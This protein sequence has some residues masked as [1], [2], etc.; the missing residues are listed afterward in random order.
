[1]KVEKHT[2]PGRD[3]AADAAVLAAE[4][5]TRGFISLVYGGEAGKDAGSA[6]PKWDGRRGTRVCSRVFLQTI[7]N[8]EGY[9]KRAG[10]NVQTIEN[11]SSEAWRLVWKAEGERK[12]NEIAETGEFHKQL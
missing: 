11:M 2:A 8:K 1:M 4:N 5:R 10:K 6:V 7:E 3:G 9:K 12:R